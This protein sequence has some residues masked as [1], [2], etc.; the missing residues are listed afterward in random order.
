MSDM[1][2]EQLLKAIEGNAVIKKMEFANN[3]NYD[4]RDALD[5]IVRKRAKS[6]RVVG[7]KGKKKK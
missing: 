5:T 4:M 2:A 3:V 7:K 6:K 1:I